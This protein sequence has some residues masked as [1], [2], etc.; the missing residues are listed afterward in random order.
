MQPRSVANRDLRAR[1][2]PSLLLGVLMLAKKL[3][4]AAWN[5]PAS[6]MASKHQH[7]GL[8]LRRNRRA[9]DEGSL[10]CIFQSQFRAVCAPMLPSPAEPRPAGTAILAL[11]VALLFAA[12]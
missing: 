1:P 5:C 6:S 10:A 9:L 4:E 12:D 11:D 7:S 8:W 2:A 3:R